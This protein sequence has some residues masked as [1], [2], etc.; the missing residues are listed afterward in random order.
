MILTPK[1][2]KF[3]LKYVES[4]NAS[5]AYREV[6]DC[7]GSKPST[8]SRKAKELLDGWHRMQM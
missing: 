4:G 2:H 5:L 3:C 7:S 6:Y 1:Q 8:V